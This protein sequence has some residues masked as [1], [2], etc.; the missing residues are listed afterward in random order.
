M[1]ESELRI[2]KVAVPVICHTLPG[3]KIAGEIFLDMLS[4][5]GYTAHQVLDFFNARPP[6]FPIRTTIGQRSIL[7]SKDSLVQVDMLEMM[8]EMREDTSLFLAQKKEVFFHLQTLGP[9]RGVVVLDLP[10]EYARVVDLLNQNRNFFPA[11]VHETFTLLNARH[12]YKIEE[13]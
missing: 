1:A 3:E 5:E 11:I 10:A 7:L 9:V 8:K 13:L 6:F 12:I 4:S 2:P